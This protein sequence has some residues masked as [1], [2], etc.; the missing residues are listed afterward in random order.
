MKI[1]FPLFSHL[2][3]E[4]HIVSSCWY[5][6]CFSC[7]V[8]FNFGGILGGKILREYIIK[9]A[10]IKLMENC[11]FL[12][13]MTISELD[14][15]ILCLREV[16]PLLEIERQQKTFIMLSLLILGE[17]RILKDIKT[18]YQNKKSDITG[19]SK[20]EVTHGGTI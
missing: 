18:L 19:S 16:L 5:A 14:S 10:D 12:F 4:I 6:K 13:S 1:V 15:L 20:E 7:W 17:K 3:G 2:T 8:R 11:S 9:M